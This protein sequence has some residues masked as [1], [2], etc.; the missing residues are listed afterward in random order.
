MS[1]VLATGALTVSRLGLATTRVLSLL[2]RRKIGC[3]AEKCKPHKRTDMAE[4]TILLIY[5]D[6]I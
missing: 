4:R 2:K 1:A 3:P 5:E 6:G